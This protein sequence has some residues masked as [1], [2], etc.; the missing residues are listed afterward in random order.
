MTFTGKADARAYLDQI[1]FRQARNYGGDTRRKP[2]RFVVQHATQGSERFDSAEIALVMWASW[3]RQ[4]SVHYAVDGD[5]TVCAVQPEAKAWHAKGGNSDTIGIE[6][7]GRAEQ[8]AAE[9]LAGPYGRGLFEQSARL[10]AA[11][12]IV[13]DIP[14]R[15]AS[16]TDHANANADTKS[17]NYTG[18]P[19]TGGLLGH[20]DIS[21]SARLRGIPTDGHW[22]PGGGYVWTH[23]LNEIAAL[24]PGTPKEAAMGRIVL[25][26]D[27]GENPAKGS[28][29][30]LL[31]D[32]RTIRGVNGARLIATA[33]QAPAAEVTLGFEIEALE[34]HPTNPRVFIAVEA[35]G[36]RTD[37]IRFA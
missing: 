16:A 10:N 33:G 19:W 21:E 11:L 32:R 37:G 22:D 18:G 27:I 1:Q 25:H 35:G 7:C 9:W 30:R 2:I 20:A 36:P 17:N 24:M 3:D 4:S 15:R 26:P 29:A 5:S 28:F 14:V 13:F 23:L 31:P 12:C 6:H 34:P 8:T